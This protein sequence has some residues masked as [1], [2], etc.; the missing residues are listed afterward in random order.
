MNNTFVYADQIFTYVNEN[1]LPIAYA[2]FNGQQAIHFSEI[3]R[4][5][6]IKARY[7]NKRYEVQADYSSNL[8]VNSDNNINIYIRG[9]LSDSFL[10]QDLYLYPFKGDVLG[11]IVLDDYHTDTVTD[12]NP[13]PEDL[14]M[15]LDN[16][17]HLSRGRL[18][19]VSSIFTVNLVGQIYN[20]PF[21]FKKIRLFGVSE[22]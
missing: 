19:F 9:D 18:K 8:L 13:P 3:K 17:S 5:N 10:L 22:R 1:T 20:G 16:P 6:K 2:D 7:A 14:G 11:T 21:S 15:R 12:N 4:V